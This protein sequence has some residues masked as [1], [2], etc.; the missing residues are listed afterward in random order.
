MSTSTA[1]DALAVPQGIDVPGPRSAPPP[2]FS[3]AATYP[4]GPLITADKRA[5]KVRCRTYPHGGHAPRRSR[6]GRRAGTTHRDLL[7]P[8][9]NAES[10]SARGVEL[11]FRNTVISTPGSLAVHRNISFELT[12]PLH[13]APLSP[14]PSRSSTSIPLTN[15]EPIKEYLF[16]HSWRQC[17]LS[18]LLP[19]MPRPK[20]QEPSISSTSPTTHLGRLS[21]SGQALPLVPPW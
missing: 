8:T 16:H 18:P 5:K 2:Q 14:S 6:G 17:S 3:T 15:P 20:H 13:T 9:R 4:E 21:P 10:Y 19:P 11:T 12:F 1:P 7:K